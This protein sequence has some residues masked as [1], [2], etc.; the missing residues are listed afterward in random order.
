[1]EYGALVHN[2]SAFDALSDS[3]ASVSEGDFIDEVLAHGCWLETTG[4][5]YNLTQPCA[6]NPPSL[7]DPNL[8]YWTSSDPNHQIYQQ[9][10]E[11][12]FPFQSESFVVASSE[13]GKRWWIGPKA[14]PGPSSSVKERL[15]LAVGY[16]RDYTKNA[17]VFL[18]IWVPTRRE[19]TYVLTGAHDHAPP[20]PS[21][22]DPSRKTLEYYRNVSKGYQLAAEEESEECRVILGKL[23]DQWTPTVRFF[24]SHEY[25]TYVNYAQQHYDL[26]GSLAL[27]VF[28]RGNGTCLGVVEIVMTNHNI[29]HHP[30]IDNACH[31]LQTVDFNKSTCQNLISPSVKVFDELYLAALNE[32]V[33]VLTSV[34]KTHNLPLA[35]TWAPCGQQGKGGCPNDNF[36]GCLSTVDSACY[37]TDLDLL[38]FQEACS[39]YHLLRGQGIVGTAFTTTKPCFATDITAFSKTEYPLSHHATMFGLHAAVAIPLR[40]VYTGSAD[41]VLE[42]FLPKNCHDGEEQKQMLNLLCVVV[43]QACRS[44]HVAMDKQMEEEFTFTVGDML[45]AASK[46]GAHKEETLEFGSC[47]LEE[48]SSKESSWIAHMMEAQ[49]Q[50]KGKGVSVSLEYL[51]EPKQEFKV[52]TNWEGA[53]VGFC[54]GQTFSD[55]GQI[56]PSSAASR[57]S[58][59]GGGESHAFG[60][61]RSSGGRKSGEK[62][63]TKAE[64]TISLPVLRQYF[65][66]SLKDAAKSIGVCP[67]TLKRICRQHGITRWPSRKI[68]KVGHSLRKL[69]LVIDSV[70]GAE[71]AIQIGSFYSSFP[72]LSSTNLSGSGPSQS[73]SISDHSKKAHARPE[74]GLYG[75]GGPTLKSPPSCCSQTSTIINRSSADFIMAENPEA[76]LKR[77]HTH[78]EA[79]LR[80]DTKHFASQQKPL[81]EHPSVEILP[82][83]PENSGWNARDGDAFRVKA[84]FG[85]EKIRF[86]LQPNWGFRELQL[87][88]ARRFNLDDVS[89]IGLKYLD[90]EGEWV[91]LTCDAD[92][93]ESKDTYRSSKNRTMRFALFQAS[94]LNLANT[95]GSNSSS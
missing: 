61:R 44:L 59:E 28:E 29:N 69:Q 83:L 95:F 6:T 37:V 88:I 94:P 75:H 72:E 21:V 3:T 35:L 66:G 82:P 78:V 49:T 4:G 76:L 89:N 38:G 77:A 36:V 8:H 17:N 86:S 84:T 71:G 2:N 53:H 33:E 12:S 60:G 34:C 27:P 65:A 11:L 51:E 48:A 58:V 45:A 22:D 47:N 87:E 93:E 19:G 73:S 81:G 13:V 25:V 16:L 79:E 70:Q 43:Q 14:N 67:T 55:Y 64:K 68:K 18:Q 7:S 32:I 1:M 80:E 42:F 74:H 23:P 41:F 24:K 10:S 92:L 26:R 50:H 30:Q 52:T 5:S 85:D 56:H 40:S 91:L 54:N 62:R 57:A 63:R 9:E 46:G 90:E 39:E 15:V 20:Y 31:S